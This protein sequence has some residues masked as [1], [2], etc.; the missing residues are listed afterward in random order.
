MTR[1]LRGITWEHERGFGSVVAASAAYAE[2]P[3]GVTVEWEA[4]SLQSFADQPIES[5]AHDYDLLVID[6]PH[7]ALA[8]EA[9]LLHP[10][11]E[12]LP[13]GLDESAFIGRSHDSY[14]FGGRQYGLATDAA[15]Q[16]AAYRPDLLPAAPET[17]E[18]VLDLAEQGLVLWPAKPIDAFSSLVTVS[19]Q[20]GGVVMSPGGSFADRAVFEQAWDLLA[21][22]TATVPSE[23]LTLNP[24]QVTEML[25]SGSR[26][27]YSP[28]LFGYTNY[29]RPGYRDNLV[30]Y[31]DIPVQT[32]GDLPV[33]ALLGGAGIAVSAFSDV[34]GPA[35]E[36]AV[37]LASSETQ[38]GS[39]FA[40][41]GQPGHL[42]AWQDS[43]LDDAASGFF[44]ETRR[45]LE[46]ATVRPAHPGYMAFQDAASVIVNEALT[47]KSGPGPV[48]DALDELFTAHVGSD[49]AGR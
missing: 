42:D 33:G 4:R 26:Y 32:A 47:R 29:S 13:A 10:L 23:C 22:L 35:S 31:T 34:H 9:G 48:A 40:G 21:R 25:A 1:V 37:W 11:D 15:A 14:R 36:F 49:H 39:Y 8:A 44:S 24:I 5:M 38:R 43:A 17:W 20:L 19:A 18:Q 3:G 46:N 41:G 12:Y 28:L 45:T 6:H 2:T 16:V 7:V 30:R 27:A